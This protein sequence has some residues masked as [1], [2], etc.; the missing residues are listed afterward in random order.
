MKRGCL[1]VIIVTLLLG[2]RD[3]FEIAKEKWENH[4]YKG[5]ELW[6]S[7]VKEHHDNYDS[8]QILLS[9][10]PDTAYSYFM[11]LAEEKMG[12]EDFSSASEAVTHALYFK[13]ADSF[14][15]RLRSEIQTAENKKEKAITAE[16]E[17]RE[18]AEIQALK[19]A[20]RGHAMNSWIKSGVW[21]FRVTGVQTTPSISDR[22]RKFHA[23][24]SIFVIV[25]MDA[26][27]DTNKVLTFWFSDKVKICDDRGNEYSFDLYHSSATSNLNGFDLDYEP[28]PAHTYLSV[29]IPF[30]I[31]KGVGPLHL[32]IERYPEEDI[33]I[34]LDLET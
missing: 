8:A 17:A 15:L 13:P 11:A 26:S 24:D 27:N 31:P 16:E 20:V 34:N 3:N 18:E 5:A 23:E 32:K 10:L 21:S 9:Q 1:S 22:Q 12:E 33:K 14:A 25:T 2:C 4:D 29:K 30:R 28:I 19:E 7:W 6:L